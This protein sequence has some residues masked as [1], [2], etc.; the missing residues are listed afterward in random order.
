MSQNKNNILIIGGPNVGKT[1][2]GGQLYGRLQTRESFYKIVSPPEN[3]NIFKEVLECLNDGKA[4]DHTNVNSNETLE[5]QI[6]DADGKNI[7]FNFPDYGGEQVKAI[8]NDRRISKIWKD[9]IEKSDSWM[10]FIRLDEIIPLEDIINRGIP[11]MDVLSK[12]NK[13]ASALK[14]SDSAFFTELLQM[15]LYA[16][17]TATL[18]K[19]SNP[20]LTIVLSC[21][22]LLEAESENRLPYELLREK[23]PLFWNY[24]V[25]TWK[26]EH[27][28]VIGLSATEKS[29]DIKKADRDFVKKGPEKFGYIITSEGKKESD[30]TLSI[31]TFIG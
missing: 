2:F 14:L 5:L 25:Q 16:K 26:A 13:E 31:G 1:H 29:L 30:L 17:R 11:E 22:D 3:L 4:A 23:L 6:V 15:L 28:D 24:L 10:L 27:L 8:F 7:T 21:W 19:I 18:G 9:Q 20:K 12:R